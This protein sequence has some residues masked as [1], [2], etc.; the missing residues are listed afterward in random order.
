MSIPFRVIDSGVQDGRK[1]IALDQALIEV[2]KAGRAP[3]T[4]RF[5]RFQ[6]TVLVGRHQA[7]AHELKVEDC[8]A[9]NV[10]IVRRITGGGAIYLD[11]NQVGWELVLSR[12]RLPL[13]LLGD[14]TRVICEAIADGLSEGFGIKARF[15]PRN[16]IEVDG[17]KLCGTG[18]FFDG[19]TLIYQ[20]TVLV[21]VDPARIMTYLCVPEAKLKKRNLDRAEDRVTTLKALLGRAPSVAEVHEALLGG[22]SR[23]LGIKPQPGDVLSEEMALA[24]R[25]HDDEIGTDEFV[26]AIDDPRH[27]QVREGAVT[28][29]GGTVT[30]FVRTDGPVGSRRIR[31][32]LIT[33]DFFVTPPRLVYDLE[34][35][36][37]GVAVTE[38]DAATRAFFAANAPDMLSITPDDFASAVA[39]AVA[40]DI[41]D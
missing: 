5:L 32:V 3:D 30:A 19:D 20:G 31:E 29:A 10:G 12:K 21:D 33:G 1:Q 6:P 2:H 22:L 15:R 24:T 17:R 41:A 14:Y 26:F 27:P 4:I 40:G 28:G 25:M 13:G 35:A 34:A 7:V 9:D 8:L 11:E 16:D 38:A 36:L 23:R 18:G 39:A 37:R